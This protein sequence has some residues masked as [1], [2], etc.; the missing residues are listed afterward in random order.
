MSQL[1]GTNLADRLETLTVDTMKTRNTTLLT[2]LALG[3]LAAF[4]PLANA[5]DST[6]KSRPD[7]PGG[8]GG[9]IVE[10]MQQMAEQLG[11]TDEQKEKIKA[12][13]QEQGEKMRALREDQNISPEDK[14]AKFREMFEALEAKTKP[15][16]TPEQQE[17]MAKFRAQRPGGAPGQGEPGGAGNLR[18]R[19]QRMAQELNL[20]DEQKEKLKE[21]FAKDGEKMKELRDNPNLS[22]EEKMAKF[23]ELNEGIE[24]RLKPILTAEQLEKWQKLRPQPGQL[25]RRPDGNK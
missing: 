16:L 20:T 10:R 6:P 7:R 4:G 22:R 2:A 13:Y 24:A 11:L 3:S 12:I 8:P 1:A 25:R 21:A 14:R 23:R 18:E 19:M 5:A 15:I 17:K 9:S